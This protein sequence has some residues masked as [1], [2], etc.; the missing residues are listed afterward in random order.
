[1]APS[2]P[3]RES[4]TASMEALM[5]LPFIAILLVLMVDMGYGQLVRVQTEV[6]TRF[7]GTSFMRAPDGADRSAHARALLEGHYAELDIRELV[8]TKGPKSPFMSSRRATHVTVSVDPPFGTL[9]NA[10]ETQASFYALNHR[11][12]NYDRVPLAV[13][14]ILDMAHD[15]KLADRIGSALAGFLSLMASLFGWLAWLLGMEP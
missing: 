13:G 5:C 6:A 8:F 4:G 14:P 15:P 10:T 9:L 1:M 2:P 3:H 12:W 7:A 11:V